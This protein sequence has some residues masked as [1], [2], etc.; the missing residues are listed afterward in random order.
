[1]TGSE[2][3]A[4]EL[5]RSVQKQDPANARAKEGLRR[6]AQ[7]FVVQANAAIDDSNAGAAEKALNAAAELAPDLADLRAARTNLR[8]LRERLDIN[9]ERAVVTPAQAEQVRKLVADAN[10]A[11]IA[12]NLIIPPGD[13]AWDKYRA[14]LA[15]DGNDREALAGIARIPARAKELFAQALTDGAPQRARALLDALR[16]TAPDDATVPALS[17]NSPTHSSIRLMHASAKAAARTP[18]THSMRRAS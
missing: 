11:S 9:A 6:I 7:S 4:L 16:Q 1:M 17:E 18:R 14:A 3:S 2:D 15:L 12:G 13:S 10:Q 8:E 5:F